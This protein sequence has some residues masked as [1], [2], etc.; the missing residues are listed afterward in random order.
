[1]PEFA[2]ISN[3]EIISKLTNIYL[4]DNVITNTAGVS[5]ATGVP[6]EVSEI[7]RK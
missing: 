5:N 3:S 1:M 4:H 7:S 2:H 6:K